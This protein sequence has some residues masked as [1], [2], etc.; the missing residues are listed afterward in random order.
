MAKEKDELEQLADLYSDNVNNAVLDGVRAWRAVEEHVRNGGHVSY[1]QR[2]EL[3]R[4]AEEIERLM[5]ARDLFG[6]HSDSGRARYRH[7]AHPSKYPA[8]QPENEGA[9]VSV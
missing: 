7:I 2:L 9:P 5:A 6:T 4:V 3:S 1:A 8:P